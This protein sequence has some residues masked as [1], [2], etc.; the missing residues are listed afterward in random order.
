MLQLSVALA[1]AQYDQKSQQVITVVVLLPG[2]QQSAV[3]KGRE[4]TFTAYIDS[5]MSVVDCKPCNHASTHELITP[6]TFADCQAEN[7]SWLDRVGCTIAHE[8]WPHGHAAHE[9]VSADPRCS[10]FGINTGLRSS[11][12]RQVQGTFQA[13]AI[14]DLL[15]QALPSPAASS[16]GCWMAALLS[17]DSYYAGHDG[18]H[19]QHKGGAS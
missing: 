15:A 1:A 19:A 5:Q 9:S 6:C 12:D 8:S 17:I 10:A 4:H 16:K 11:A 13:A 7:D 3:K 2:Q 18:A 14:F